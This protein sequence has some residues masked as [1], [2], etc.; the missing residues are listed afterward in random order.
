MKERYYYLIVY[1]SNKVTK[2]IINISDVSQLLKL[3]ILFTLVKLNLQ[4]I[5]KLF[6]TIID[7]IRQKLK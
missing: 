7:I 3:K 1:I 5:I 4:A 2:H 6:L